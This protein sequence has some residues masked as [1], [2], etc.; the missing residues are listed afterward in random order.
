[1]VKGSL[2][3][4]STVDPQY[5]ITIIIERGL[6]KVCTIAYNKPFYTPFSDMLLSSW[7]LGRKSSAK[8]IRLMPQ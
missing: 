1:M 8:N 3:G 5:D 6:N 4:Y 7:L 2:C